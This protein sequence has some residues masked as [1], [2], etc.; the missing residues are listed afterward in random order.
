MTPARRT[1][2]VTAGALPLVFDDQGTG[3]GFLLLH[4]GAGP[5][6]M[7]GLANL[8]AKHGRVVAPIHP[9]FSGTPR[10][11]WCARI[12]DL[13]WAYL[14][15]IEQLDLS[16]VIL[17]GNSVGGWIAAEIALRG[18]RRV[19]GL[20]LLNAVGVGTGDPARPIVD[21][22][23]LPPADRLARAFHDPGRFARMPPAPEAAAVLA[24]DQRTLRVYAGEPFM[25]DPGLSLRLARLNLPAFV[26]WG[27]SD[28]IVDP[29]YGRRFA[30]SIPNAA[31]HP[32]ADAGHF[33]QVEQ[34]RRV[35]GLIIELAREVRTRTERPVGDG[36]VL[37]RPVER[38]LAAAQ[39]G[40]ER[41]VHTPVRSQRVESDDVD[42]PGG[43][44]GL[45]LE[46]ELLG[47]ADEE[48]DEALRDLARPRRSVVHEVRSSVADACDRRESEHV[49]P[50][51]TLPHVERAVRH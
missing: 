6:T 31:F 17:V 40:L 15:L 4:G 30:D 9:G 14:A 19:A 50:G 33:P 49:V 20:V 13:A 34:P 21:P 7:T 36:Q 27:E 22:M 29:S 10:P 24:E 32:V 45:A 25:H 8:L 41:L 11:D 47:V 42:V 28:R 35:A 18:S 3:P 5:T 12:A 23:A 16:Q 48:L 38:G 44:Q 46:A 26:V 51:T 2:A 43:R 1:T 39:R 37:H